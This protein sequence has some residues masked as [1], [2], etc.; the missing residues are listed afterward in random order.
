MMGYE[1]FRYMSDEDVYSLVAY[2]NTLAPVKNRVPRSRIDFPVS[3]LIKSAPRP[4]GHVPNPDRS[5]RVKYG[6]Y[7]VTLAGCAQCHTPSRRGK[8]LAGMTLAGGEEFRFPG[9]MVVV[10]ANITPDLETGIGRWSEQD[11][12]KRIYQYKEYAEKGSPAVGPESFTVMPWLA[13][14]QLEADDL[15][16][17]YAFLRTERPVYHAVDSHP[18]WQAQDKKQRPRG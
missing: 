18:V 9:G 14:A 13:F 3:L 1:R 7:L 5:N 2:L 11:F 17:I 15:K 10:S 4:A 16:A 8:L 6:E 12:L